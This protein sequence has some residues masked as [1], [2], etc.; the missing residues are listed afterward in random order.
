MV[1][2]LAYQCFML[3][4][5]FAEDYSLE[6]PV[7]IL[8]KS[9]WKLD[10]EREQVDLCEVRIEETKQDEDI[11]AGAWQRWPTSEGDTTITTCYPQSHRQTTNAT[12]ALLSLWMAAQQIESFSSDS[13]ELPHSFQFGKPTSPEV[14]EAR[15]VVHSQEKISTASSDR[16]RATVLS[17]F[18]C[19]FCK[20]TFSR[21]SVV[22][23]HILHC[24]ERHNFSNRCLEPDCSLKNFEFLTK[25]SLY[26]HFYT[27]HVQ[28][29]KCVCNICGKGFKTA[30]YVKR[31]QEAMH[32]VVRPFCCAICGRGFVEKRQLDTHVMK[33]H[34]R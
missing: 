13:N 25:V 34:Q 9:G 24:H 22:C 28:G 26:K 27:H 21:R 8:T 7:K 1:L 32:T 23:S 4:L 31:H 15:A 18:R 17:R 30:G 19:M 10:F 16:R 20:L 33:V 11:T 14:S 12:A 29:L 6:E 3:L 5:S 2:R